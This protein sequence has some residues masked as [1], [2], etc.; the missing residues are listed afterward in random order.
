MNNLFD[1]K[2]DFVEK[3]TSFIVKNVEMVQEEWARLLAISLLSTFLGDI[4]IVKKPPVKLNLYILMIASSGT[5]KSLPIIH[6]VV[7]I[8]KKVGVKLSKDFMLPTKSSV[9]GFIKDLVDNM[10][11]DGVIISHEFSGVF[12]KS[13]ESGYQSDALEF[14]SENYD[15]IGYDRSTISHGKQ[16]LDNIYIGILACST[17][18]FLK[19]MDEDFFIQGTGNRFLYNYFDVKNFIIPSKDEEQMNKD[20]GKIFSSTGYDRYTLGIDN[21][22]NELCKL[23]KNLHGDKALLRNL[24]LSK[25]AAIEWRKYEIQALEKWKELLTDI[26]NWKGLIINRYPLTVLKLAGIY[27]ISRNFRKIID[28]ESKN[29]LEDILIKRKDVK[30]AIK[31]V[32]THHKH[33][34]E[35]LEI[36]ERAVIDISKNVK[37]EERAYAALKSLLRFKNHMANQ[38]Q[39]RERQSVTTSP[40]TFQTYVNIGLK[41]GWIEEVDKSTI[42]NNEERE[43]LKVST[44]AKVYRWIH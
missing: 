14:M 4:Q 22:S 24:K 35:L 29:D 28:A 1:E 6:V 13:R 11:K 33:F 7:K 25:Q 41:E 10:Q 39:L 17:P 40:N 15:G 3:L 31:T 36:K 32:M 42:K 16:K 21:F 5:R 23:Y 27:C 37:M 18:Y 12:K 26:F 2:E 19:K 8:L 44:R 20:I 9:E 38:S 43:R 34:K 30:R